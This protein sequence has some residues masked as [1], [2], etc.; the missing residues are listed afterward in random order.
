LLKNLDNRVHFNLMKLNSLADLLINAAATWPDSDA[1]IFPKVQL[2]DNCRSYQQ[3]FD[4][5]MTKAKGLKAMGIQAGDHVG[6]FM[7]DCVDY[8]ESIYGICLAGARPVPINARYRATELAY[9]VNNADVKLLLSSAIARDYLDIA[10]MLTRTFPELANSTNTKNLQLEKAPLLKSIVLLH[11]ESSCGFT[12]SKA[13]YESADHFSDEDIHLQRE[14]IDDHQRAIIIYTSGTTANPKGCILSDTMLL[15]NSLAMAEQ[16]YYL[17]PEDRFWDPLPLFHMAA[18]LPML[19]VIQTG[20]AFACMMHFDVDVALKMLEEERISIAFLTFPPITSALINHPDFKNTDLSRIR[21]INNVAPP[22]TLAIFQKAFPGAVQTAAFGMTEAGGVI[23]FNDP[24]EDLHSRLHTCGR[25]FDDIEVKIVD[26]ESG[27]EVARG[28]QGEIIIRGYNLFDGY[29]KNPEATAAAVDKDGWFHSGDIC[30]LN[31]AGNIRYHGRTKD[32]LKV[33]GENV[34]AL[35]IESYLSMHP[36]V[37]MVQVVGK[38]DPVMIEVPAAFIELKDNV[39]CTEDEIIEFC[40]DEIASFK[41][42]RLVRFV[43]DWPMSATKV[44]K[45]RLRELLEHE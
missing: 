28:E 25:P 41:I 5:A 29:Y 4:N 45:F 2:K 38:S 21:R 14:Q 10:S 39:V 8:V 11:S 17:Q 24:S 16:R 42:P 27:D 12:G 7:P 20:G 33:G 3:L 6:I 31:E 34:S 44:Q 43:T 18:I 13:F 36:A 22:D 9:V 40:K 35:E 37:K 1:L 23:S 19:A 30:S 26:P 32:M 15:R